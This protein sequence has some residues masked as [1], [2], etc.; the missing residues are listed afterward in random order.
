MV[1]L[2]PG[3]TGR[4]AAALPAGGRTSLHVDLD[5][6]DP[7]FGMANQY[8]VGP[9]I[10]PDDLLEAVR[11]VAAG[12]TLAAVTLSAYDPA[13]DGGGGVREAALAALRLVRARAPAR[14]ASRG[15]S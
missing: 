5:V 12:S 7:A 11:A 15:G 10:G 9:G 4:L 14:S 3:E 8:A 13:F 6:L 2:G 1:E